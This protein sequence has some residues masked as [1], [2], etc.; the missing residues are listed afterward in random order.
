MDNKKYASQ[1]VSNEEYRRIYTELLQRIKSLFTQGYALLTVTGVVWTL[2]A[3]ILGVLFEN[4]I[5][6]VS[7]ENTVFSLGLNF[8][9]IILF[10]LPTLLA[11]PFSV[12]HHDNLRAVAS[13]SAYTKVFYEL[14]LIVTASDEEKDFCYWETLHCESGLSRARCFNFEYIIATLLSDFLSISFCG[15]LVFHILENDLLKNHFVPTILFLCFAAIYEIIAI[16]IT[17]HVFRYGHNVIYIRLYSETYLNE[18]LDRAIDIGHIS[19]TQKSDY[20]KHYEGFLKKDK[21]ITE[22]FKA[23]FKKLKAKMKEEKKEEKR[24]KKA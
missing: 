11:F 21:K 5:L 6:D 9:V 20:I 24:K 16:I 1:K 7:T 15:I 4:K 23:S 2:A 3:T 19:P 13:L 10:G 8:V 18:Y 17:V 14:P 22:N 12:K